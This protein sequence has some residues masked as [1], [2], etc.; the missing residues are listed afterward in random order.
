MVSNIIN[1]YWGDIVLKLHC[2]HCRNQKQHFFAESK[3]T[4]DWPYLSILIF[5]L[6]KLVTSE[7]IFVSRFS[8]IRVYNNCRSI[9]TIYS[10]VKIFSWMNRVLLDRNDGSTWWSLK[11]IE[12]QASIC[13]QIGFFPKIIVLEGK[14][15]NLKQE[16]NISKTNVEV[17]DN[18]ANIG[19]APIGRTLILILGYI[20]SKVE[21]K[22]ILSI[23]QNM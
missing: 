16:I 22:S 13:K 21:E 20:N 9:P 6:I 4:F 3:P 12:F 1:G 7:T 11:I 5:F 15:S 14:M 2:F 23:G 19:L 17:V 18:H 8:E 10:L